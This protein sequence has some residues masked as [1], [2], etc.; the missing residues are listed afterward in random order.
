MLLTFITFFVTH[1]FTKTLNI[2]SLCHRLSTMTA[3]VYHYIYIIVNSNLFQ[4]IPS[5]LK[6]F[7]IY[8]LIDIFTPGTR[9]LFI[10]FF[11]LALIS[12]I[13]YIVFAHYQNHP[14]YIRKL[15]LHFL[16][17]LY[18]TLYVH[19]SSYD[20]AYWEYLGSIIIVKEKIR[21][22]KIMEMVL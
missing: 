21:W 9:V 14:W 6:L 12:Y 13:F 1:I 15:C 16:V 5:F 18:I 11:T 2:L 17:I 20:L 19:L 8:W 4:N 22:E 10:P 3:S 7:Y